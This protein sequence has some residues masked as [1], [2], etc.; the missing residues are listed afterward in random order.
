MDSAVTLFTS[1]C[2]FSKNFRY[3]AMKFS[4]FAQ[5]IEI[6]SLLSQAEEAL[7]TRDFP[8][9]LNAFGEIWVDIDLTPN[10]SQ[11]SQEAELLHLAGEFLAHYGKAYN[12][13]NYQS[14]G[15]DLLTQAIDLFI[16]QGKPEK[17]LNSQIVLAS[18]YFQEGAKEEYAVYLIDAECQFKGDKT[19]YNFLKLQLNLIVYELESAQINEAIKR[20]SDNLAFFQ[21]TD[22]LKIKTQFFI[23]AG[24]TNRRLKSYDEAYLFF[25]EALKLSKKI[26]NLHYEALICNNLANTYRS[27]SKFKQA[28]RFADKAITLAGNQQGWKAN[29]LD[30]KALIYYDQKDYENAELNIE[31][32]IFLFRQGDDF[33]GLCEALW[34]KTKILL[35]LDLRELAF[36]TFIECYQTAR[37]RIGRESAHFYL[38]KQLELMSF[39]PEGNL[40]EKVD[41]VKRQ[42]IEKALIEANGKITEAAKILRID[43]RSLSAMMKNFPSLYAD[44]GIRRKNRSINSKNF[45]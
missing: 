20:I 22:N 43:H 35:Q 17:A 38:T 4:P 21:K 18:A 10:F 24:I 11:F 14:R 45:R 28:L 37:E 41:S 30:T 19:H 44:L 23:E 36:E 32:S 9:F 31:E 12:L 15:K 29:F 1:I 16:F 2:N 27:D 39:V 7:L 42:L 13:I 6:Y 8:T 3:L 40:F 26:Q 34:N 25:N 33:G 5:N